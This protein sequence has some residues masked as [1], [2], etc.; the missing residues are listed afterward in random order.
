[1]PIPLTRLNLR[2]NGAVRTVHSM[3]DS[4]DLATVDIDS[5]DPSD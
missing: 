4:N 3:I 2:M 1:M 5:S